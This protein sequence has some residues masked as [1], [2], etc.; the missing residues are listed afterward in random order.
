L[1][2]FKIKHADAAY[3]AVGILEATCSN[4]IAKKAADPLNII[5]F[6]YLSSII[7]FSTQSSHLIS[8]PAQTASLS[9]TSWIQPPSKAVEALN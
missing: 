6:G 4:F 5:I 3:L 7:I 8:H 1:I 2:L 9:P